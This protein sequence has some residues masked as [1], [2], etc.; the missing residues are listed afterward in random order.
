MVQPKKGSEFEIANIFWLLAAFG[1]THGINEL[2]DMWAVIKGRNQVLDI[3]RWLFLF[4]SYIFLIEFGRRLFSLKSSNTPAWQKKLSGYLSSWIVPAIGIFIIIYSS[5]SN[6]FWST[7][8]ILARYLLGLPGGLLIGFGFRLYYYHEDNVLKSLKVKKYFLF[9][10]ASFLIY[11]FLGGVIV[12]KGDFFPSNI[13]NNQSFLITFKIPVQVFRTVCAITATWAI[14]GMLQIFNWE[15]RTKLEGAQVSLKKQLRESESRYMEIV[16][17]SSDIIYSI[18][19]DGY[20]ISSNDRGAR[21]LDFLQSELIGKQFSEITS[22]ETQQKV[23]SELEKIKREGSVFLGEGDLIKKDGDA[24]DVAMHSLVMFDNN[25]NYLGIRLILRD[26]TE[27]KRMEAEISKIEKLESV[28]IMAGGLAH[29]FNNILTA[30]TGNIS[31][32]KAKSSYDSSMFNILND[33]QKACRH[34]RNLT[35]QLLTFSKGG[36][37]VKKVTDIRALIKDSAQFALRGSPISCLIST[38]EDLWPVEIDE[39]QII[40]VIHNL[41]LNSKQAMPHG[42]SIGIRAENIAYS[43]NHIPTLPSGKVVKITVKDQGSGILK[44]IVN[45]IFDPFFTTKQHGSGLG[46]ACTYSI[47][48]N[49]GGHIEVYSEVNIGT[50]FIIHLPASDKEAVVEEKKKER[51]IEGSGYILLMEDEESVRN[52][53]CRMLRHMGYEAEAVKNGEEAIE[54]YRKVRNSNRPFDAVIIDL[55]IKGGMGGKDAIKELT[56]MDPNV[57]AIVSSGYFNDPIMADFRDYGFSGVIPKPYEIDA[58]G[59]LLET[60]INRK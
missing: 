34:A 22:Q 50:T 6:D 23:E 10:G 20:I 55:T 49:H 28:G 47:V 56:R 8:S 60:V 41:V 52:S 38:A 13:I 43:K 45:K 11:G 39:G 32:A 16:N 1:I 36:S 30:I 25:K 37:P 40:Q 12:P 54:L 17:S 46:L 58:L 18:D 35:S 31:L 21:L 42:G 48:K 3:F 4:T 27:S 53:V 5:L 44:N 2:L 19:T 33:A 24:L 9:G 15:I 14:A 26:I 59:E 29:D 51:S 7:G 57:K